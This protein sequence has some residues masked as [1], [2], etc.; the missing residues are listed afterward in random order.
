MP[1]ITA[2][3]VVTKA[4]ESVKES[5][6]G[7]EE[8]VPLS[9]QTKATFIKHAHHDEASGEPVMNEKEFVDAIAPENEDYVSQFGARLPHDNI[10]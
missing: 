9:A 2:S 7:T 8:P 4:K 5:L 10:G 1:S 6:F 3:P